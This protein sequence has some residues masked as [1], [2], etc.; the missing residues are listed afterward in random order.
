[1]RVV[2][3]GAGIIGVQIAVERF[4]APPWV[5]LPGPLIWRALSA[6]RRE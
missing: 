4:G 1:M 5:R 3:V 2:V 6:G